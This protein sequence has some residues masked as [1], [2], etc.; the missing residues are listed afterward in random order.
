MNLDGDYRTIE[1]R[2]SRVPQL[3]WAGLVAGFL[4][5]LGVGM[6]AEL[7]TKF[8]RPAGQPGALSGPRP[9]VEVSK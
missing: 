3:F 9:A 2:P 1:T 6:A 5:G 8:G 7:G 4:L